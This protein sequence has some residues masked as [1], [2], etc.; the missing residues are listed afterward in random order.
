MASQRSGAMPG[1]ASPGSGG[2][3]PLGRS[4]SVDVRSLSP[5]RISIPPS[6]IPRGA[7]VE[8]RLPL[9]TRADALF[10]PTELPRLHREGKW[11]ATVFPSLHPSGREEVGMVEEWL[12]KALLERS[13][14]LGF[15]GS[16]AY[17]N[18]YSTLPP[19]FPPPL[20]HIPRAWQ[21]L[22]AH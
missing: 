7:H 14:S 22:Y 19:P 6:R 1:L 2:M 21:S 10:L 9:K 15:H 13:R 11:L 16:Y 17:K 5:P 18:Y 12:E 20:P 4:A 3:P 8:V